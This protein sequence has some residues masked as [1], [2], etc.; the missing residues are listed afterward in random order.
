[1]IIKAFEISIMILYFQNFR[2]LVILYI[3]QQIIFI[4]RITMRI[5]LIQKIQ[6][7]VTD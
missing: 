7:Q 5:T 2:Q 4:K 6:L 1:M 3:R